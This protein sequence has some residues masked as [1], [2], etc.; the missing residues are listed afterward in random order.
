[1]NLPKC[2]FHL[3]SSNTHHCLHLFLFVYEG[4]GI[5]LGTTYTRVFSP[6]QTFYNST[7]PSHEYDVSCAITPDGR[8]I[9]TKVIEKCGY[10]FIGKSAIGKTALRGFKNDITKQESQKATTLFI[11]RLLEMIERLDEGISNK[12]AQFVFGYS[13]SV[14]ILS[15]FS[16]LLCH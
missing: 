3:I 4:I 8:A 1:M 11:R 7:L 12:G 9:E 13:L 16:N 5:D 10:I 14:L 6:I 15:F 2:L